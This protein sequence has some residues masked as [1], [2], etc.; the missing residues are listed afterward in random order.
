MLWPWG[1][2]L[3]LR[4]VLKPLGGRPCGAQRPPRGCTAVAPGASWAGCRGGQ[5]PMH[6]QGL[7]PHSEVR[8]AAGAVPPWPS[9][10]P[11]LTGGPDPDKGSEV[12]WPLR[13]PPR[14]LFRDEEARPHLTSGPA[15]P[16]PSDPP[17]GV[18]SPQGPP[19]LVKRGEWLVCYVG[20]TCGAL[21]LYPH[22]GSSQARAPHGDQK[23]CVL[24]PSSWTSAAEGR[25]A[26]ERG[27]G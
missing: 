26:E 23:S 3:R 13:H 4:P 20:A 8:P 12:A 19:N 10:H 6:G 1:R 21:A 11:D 15:A 7:S 17:R 16:S 14:A 2:A 27:E 5:G 25:A 22:V 9:A 18:P 24:I